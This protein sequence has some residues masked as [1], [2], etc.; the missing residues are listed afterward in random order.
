MRTLAAK[1]SSSRRRGR[2]DGLAQ[3]PALM[4]VYR[5]GLALYRA[6]RYG[7]ATPLYEKAL[8]L[9]EWEFGSEHP[10]TTTFLNNL[11]LVYKAQGRYKERRAPL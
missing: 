10:A 6:G 8:E 9:G 4:Q 2:A 5:Q 11:A 1:F 7:E 3:S